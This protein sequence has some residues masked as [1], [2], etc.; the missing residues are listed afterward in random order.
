MVLGIMCI[1]KAQTAT[2]FSILALGWVLAISGVVWFV[3]SFQAWTW[4]GF[5]VYL[6]NAILRCV[7][8]YLLIRHPDAG[9]EGVTMVLAALFIVGG[10]FRV[11][12]ASAIQ[13]PRWG[14]TGRVEDWRGIP[15][16]EPICFSPFPLGGFE[17]PSLPPRFQTFAQAC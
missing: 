9:A 16:V 10:L 12:A 11:A 14:W 1:G 2:T 13:F 4:V 17:V 6:L 15:K 7:T 5:L 8:G 3:N